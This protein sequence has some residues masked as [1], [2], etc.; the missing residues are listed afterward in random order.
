LLFAV[1]LFATTQLIIIAVYI[2]SSSIICTFHLIQRKLKYLYYPLHH[3]TDIVIEMPPSIPMSSATFTRVTA[4]RSTDPNEICPPSCLICT[5][6]LTTNP[7]SNFVLVPEPAVTIVKCGHVFG[8]NCLAEWM[9]EHN[10]CPVCRA[11][12]FSASA[13]SLRVHVEVQVPQ[14]FA[15]GVY[16]S[17][18]QVAVN[19]HEVDLQGREGLDFA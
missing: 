8:R 10:T 9:R 15:M 18:V 11:E 14:H 7:T 16:G 3:H 19:G 2:I 5:E 6:T 12:F 13:G 17:T 1:L 4:I